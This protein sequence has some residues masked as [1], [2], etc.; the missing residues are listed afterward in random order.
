MTAIWRRRIFALMRAHRSYCDQVP[1]DAW[2]DTSWLD[3]YQDLSAEDA[4]KLARSQQ[5]AFRVIRPRTL[6]TADRNIQRLN[7]LLDDDGSLICF[8]AF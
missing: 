1:P 7:I 2:E 4:E 6:H 3:D 5:R 8:K